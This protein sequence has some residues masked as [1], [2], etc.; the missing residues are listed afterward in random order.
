MQLF[1]DF[2]DQRIDLAQ[3][4]SLTFG[5]E[6]DLVLDTNPRLPPVVGRFVS[7]CGQWWLRNERRDDELLVKDLCSPSRCSIAPGAEAPLWFPSA[8]VAFACG[9][10]RYEVSLAL[11]VPHR[12]PRV[13]TRRLNAEQR[14]LLL[15]LAEN[16]LRSRGRDASLPS[17]AQAAALLGWSITKLNR[18][19]DHL[20]IKFAKLGV[21]G[22]RGSPTR[23]ASDRRRRLV[24]HCIAEGIVSVADLAVTAPAPRSTHGSARSATVSA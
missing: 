3:A 12:G 21:E 1:V 16:R 5:R 20:C 8:A 2:L 7:R 15:V 24:D 13:S 11:G 17:N 23:L 19:L 22:L 14:A 18:K 9:P 10:A 6:A 4:E